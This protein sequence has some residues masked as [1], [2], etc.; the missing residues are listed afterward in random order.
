M[1]DDFDVIYEVDGTDEDVTG[2]ERAI[3]VNVP[4]PIIIRGAGNV[5]VYVINIAG[6]VC[7]C[8]TIS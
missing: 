5:T 8:K 4:D 3:V 1:A 7:S 2:S 6:F